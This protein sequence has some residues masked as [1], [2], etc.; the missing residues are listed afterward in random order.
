MTPMH[1]AHDDSIIQVL[2][3]GE[4]GLRQLCDDVFTPMPQLKKLDLKR[5]DFMGIS[6]YAWRGLSSSLLAS[7]M[8]IMDH[9]P[10]R[11]EV[12]NGKVQ[13]T[14]IPDKNNEE[15]PLW[16]SGLQQDMCVCNVGFKQK[17]FT[18]D[19]VETRRCIAC[20]KAVTLTLPAAY[21][22]SL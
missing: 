7:R 3:L 2:T 10:S 12:K 22:S 6:R 19:E 5:N 4:N 18:S 21:L 20:P 9:S 11:C 8:L 16:T 14:C 13:C 1:I 17:Y 15:K